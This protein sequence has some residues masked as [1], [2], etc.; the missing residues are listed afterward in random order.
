[1]K[2]QD[3]AKN[4]ETKQ[5]TVTRFIRRKH[6][7]KWS[8]TKWTEQGGRVDEA[9][10]PREERLTLKIACESPKRSF[11]EKYIAYY[12]YCVFFSR[13]IDVIHLKFGFVGIYYL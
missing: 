9:E 5:Q 6:L 2:S 11:L 3:E 7:L 4:C 10:E 12:G 13:S 8:V 1:M